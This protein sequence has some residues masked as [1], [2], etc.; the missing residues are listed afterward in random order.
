MSKRLNIYE[1]LLRNAAMTDEGAQR[2]CDAAGLD[3][4]GRATSDAVEEWLDNEPSNREMQS[5]LYKMDYDCMP[6]IT[7]SKLQISVEILQLLTEKLDG[8]YCAIGDEIIAGKEALLEPE[9]KILRFVGSISN[10]PA[11]LK[12]MQKMA[13]TLLELAKLAAEGQK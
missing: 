4:A 7:D 10:L 11:R 9:R 12:E 5:A 13:G 2:I 1:T 6:E 8:E 3:Y